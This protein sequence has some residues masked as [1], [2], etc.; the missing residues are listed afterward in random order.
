MEAYGGQKVKNRSGHKDSRGQSIIVRRGWKI[1]PIP[2]LWLVCSTNGG[3]VQV[4]T[5]WCP[6]VNN[7]RLEVY[8]S[9][10]SIRVGIW[11]CLGEKAHMTDKRNILWRTSSPDRCV[12]ARVLVTGSVRVYMTAWDDCIDCLCSDLHG[13]RAQNPTRSHVST[14]L[15]SDSFRPTW[16][17]TYPT[18]KTVY[19]CHLFCGWWWDINLTSSA[20]TNSRAPSLLGRKAESRGTCLKYLGKDNARLANYFSFYNDYSYP[21]TWKQMYH[22]KFESGNSSDRAK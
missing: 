8:Q 6:I 17:I 4:W 21:Y 22:F 5:Q 2:S 3:E 14:W 16:T 1:W 11:R 9:R 18:I 7:I 19:F 20:R 13:S 12:H 15:V 10:Y